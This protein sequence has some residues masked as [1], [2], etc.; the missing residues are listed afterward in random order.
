MTDYDVEMNIIQDLFDVELNECCPL[1]DKNM[2]RIEEMEKILLSIINEDSFKKNWYD[3]SKNTNAPPD[4]ISE[5]LSLCMDIMRVDDHS[6]GKGKNECRRLESKRHDELASIF[7]NYERIYVNE[8]TGL[9]QNLDHNYSFY[10]KEFKRVID[11]HIRRLK[12]YK[13]NYGTEKSLF[14]VADESSGTYYRRKKGNYGEL[15][16][17]FYDKRFVESFIDSELDYLIW[18]AP[19]KF[20]ETIPPKRE[21]PTVVFYDIKGFRSRK[22]EL[23]DYEENM[24]CINED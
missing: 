24:M 14:L 21:Y 22:N 6:Q 3:N 11:K 2:T 13:N 20:F 9:E 5:N 19:Y 17:F 1:G 4:F 23:I 15:H 7:N 16:I 10:Y 12:T 8:Q 18:F